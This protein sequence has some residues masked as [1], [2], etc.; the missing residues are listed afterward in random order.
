MVGIMTA[1][2]FKASKNWEAK[3]DF[4]EKLWQ[5]DS[6]MQAGLLAIFRKGTETIPKQ[7]AIELLKGFDR[8]VR[9][10]RMHVWAIAL[11]SGVGAIGA[12]GVT[13]AAGATAS[14]FGLLVAT[15][16]AVASAILGVGAYDAFKL[17]N[18]AER[19]SSVVQE[20]I[21]A[22]QQGKH[23]SVWNTSEEQRTAWSREFKEIKQEKGNLLLVPL[24]QGNYQPS[25]LPKR[26]RNTL[27]H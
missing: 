8:E 7:Q 26:P 11:F 13:L 23:E 9:D 17:G 6:L 14:V 27:S 10:A 1:A 12:I 18:M 2:E 15:V 19:V 21:Q 22:L 16:A 4:V 25:P 24:L 3:L 5:R 20:F